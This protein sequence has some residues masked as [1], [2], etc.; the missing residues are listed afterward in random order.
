MS[1]PFALPF[2]GQRYDAFL[3]A[4]PPPP[5][6]PLLIC[7]PADPFAANARFLDDVY[8]LTNLSAHA[9]A[10]AA[11][12]APAAAEAAATAEAQRTGRPAVT[13]SSDPA[14]LAAAAAASQLPLFTPLG[15]SRGGEAPPSTD[16]PS[17]SRPEV[18]C[19]LSGGPQHATLLPLTS[20]WRTTFGKT[21]RQPPLWVGYS[22][23]SMFAVSRT[24]VLAQRPRSEPTRAPSKLYERVADACAPVG[25]RSEPVAELALERLWRHIFVPEDGAD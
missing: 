15:L 16:L 25:R 12:A 14:A 11:A 24:A 10:S 5:F 13:S 2:A 1:S 9:Q 22:P 6:P 8:I 3:S 21:G 20:L 18:F 7:T 17:W 4:P 23:S 19:D